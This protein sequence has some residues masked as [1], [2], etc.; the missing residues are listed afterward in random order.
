MSSAQQQCFLDVISRE[1]D[2]LMNLKSTYSVEQE[3]L[4]QVKKVKERAPFYEKDD[5]PEKEKR[6]QMQF[7]LEIK[8]DSEEKKALLQAVIAESAAGGHPLPPSLIKL[9]HSQNSN[10]HRIESLYCKLN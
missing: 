7:D 1:T 8:R 5:G 10:E 2:K 6:E 9:M 4:H 3:R